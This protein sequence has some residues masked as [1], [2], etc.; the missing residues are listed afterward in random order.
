M[1]NLASDKVE[2]NKKLIDS[3]SQMSKMAAD[4]QSLISKMAA[5]S[6]LKD[7]EIIAFEALF[8]LRALGVRSLTET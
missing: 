1:K 5:D 2:L 8:K 4:S 3:Q 6:Q 7:K